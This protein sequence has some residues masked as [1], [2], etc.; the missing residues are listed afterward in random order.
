MVRQ[1][2]QLPLLPKFSDTL[3][4]SQPWGTDYAR[5]LALPCLKKIRDYVPDLKKQDKARQ[6]KN[7]GPSCKYN[8]V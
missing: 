4:I 5:P 1:A 2:R 6:I 3:T 7:N 8:W